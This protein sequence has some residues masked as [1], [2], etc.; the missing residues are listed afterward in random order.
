MTAPRPSRRVAPSESDLM[1][2]TASLI[3]SACLALL[4]ACASQTPARGQ[5]RRPEAR[6]FDEFTAGP[7]GARVRWWYGRDEEARK[8]LEARFRLYA[9]Q[10]RKEGA[11]PYAIT[12]GPRVVE[13]EIYDRSVAGMR[14]GAL[15]EYLTPAG[16]DGEQI[17]WV[18]G[19]F[20]EEAATEL[21]VVPPGAQPPCPTPTVRPEDVAY[22][23][24]VR[25][26]ATTYV[27]AP[28]GRLRFKADV[29]ANDKKVT[30]TFFWAVSAGRI[31]GGEGTGAIEV[32][33]PPGASGEVVARV[34]VR[35]Y[36]LECP[37][38]SSAAYAK[39]TFG[40]THFKLDEFGDIRNGDTKARLDNLAVLLQE[41]P[42]LQAHLV[43]YGGRRGARGQATRRA[44]WLKNYM[45]TTRALDPA[46]VITVEGGF[47]DEL[48]GELWLSPR[49][50][51][52]P[53]PKP[54]VDGR[55]AAPKG[56]VRRKP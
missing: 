28:S 9:A 25:V 19:G 44:E 46:R 15:W 27:P 16:F 32:E 47:R 4:L 6:K 17:N 55:Y 56:G 54:T 48:S 14:A 3:S 5:A 24:Y 22:C 39:T 26:E 50:A 49:G 2:Q 18:N 36:S 51:P 30:P 11:R 45:V 37:P 33:P 31:V 35:G 20:R 41:D 23:P 29:N 43:V 53:P 12:Y 38:E 8:E 34:E 21:W 7:A 52:A 13:W 1:K 42:T 40:V 10:L